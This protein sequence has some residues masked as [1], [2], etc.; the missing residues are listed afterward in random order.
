VC[1]KV[2]LHI[3]SGQTRQKLCQTNGWWGEEWG[4]DTAREPME[5]EEGAQPGQSDEGVLGRARE[6]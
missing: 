2:G 3:G 6:L 5:E 4:E 1:D